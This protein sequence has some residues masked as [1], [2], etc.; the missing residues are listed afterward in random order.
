M[1]LS[2]PSV[3]KAV[4]LYLCDLSTLPLS[5][6]PSHSA[7]TISALLSPSPRHP[8]SPQ[9]CAFLVPSPTHFHMHASHPGSCLNILPI[10]FALHPSA[11]SVIPLI[12][13]LRG[14]TLFS[15]IATGR[16]EVCFRDS[17]CH[18]SPLP[19]SPYPSYPGA[20]LSSKMR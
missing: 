10:V 18:S 8:D 3:E 5:F 14:F 6:C 17:L 19:C 11:L 1:L 16:K 13:L 4:I 2:M 9:K 12:S 20:D 15:K 7:L